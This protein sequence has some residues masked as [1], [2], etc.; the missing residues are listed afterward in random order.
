ME[1]MPLM[2][3]NSWVIISIGH[4]DCINSN[5]HN[6]NCSWNINSFFL[7]LNIDVVKNYGWLKFNFHPTYYVDLKD[8]GSLHKITVEC[9]IGY[10]LVTQENS[11]GID[12]HR[13]THPANLYTAKNI[14]N[15]DVLQ[16]IFGLDEWNLWLIILYML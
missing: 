2:I 6:T 10:P 8:V 9:S 15:S 5:S 3:S 11:R 14:Y 7:T 4:F 1:V 13:D 12:I 16:L